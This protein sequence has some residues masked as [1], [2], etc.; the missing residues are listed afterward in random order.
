MFFEE[1]GRGAVVVY[2]LEW[3]QSSYRADLR[4]PHEIIEIG[5]V[6]V[7]S[8]WRVTDTFSRL[9]RPRV[10]KKLDKH[11]RTVTG[12]TEEELSGGDP[13]ENVFADFRR[14]SEGASAFITWGRDDY[15]VLRRN[16]RYF[17][18]PLPFGPPL[19]AQLV[20]AHACLG[21][22]HQQ[23]NL[24]GALEFLQLSPDV[25]AHRAVYDAQCTALLLPRLDA[26]VRGANEAVMDALRVTGFDGILN[27]D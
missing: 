23:M 6:R 27:L 11:I 3:N 26:A 19:D 17:R 2:D 7:D 24:H 21:D 15:P 8:A 10:Y 20:F 1:N 13:F 25:P 14:F 4:M 12:I 16:A 22:A 18:Q 9:I 5:A